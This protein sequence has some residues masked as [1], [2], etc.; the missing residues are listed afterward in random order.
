[1]QSNQN[2]ER[3]LACKPKNQEFRGR[4]RDAPLFLQKKESE[5]K[6]AILIHFLLDYYRIHALYRSVLFTKLREIDRR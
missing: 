4:G 1:M 2:N 3:F 5:L 6:T